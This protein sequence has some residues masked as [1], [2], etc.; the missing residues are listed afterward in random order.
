MFDDES[1]KK[2]SHVNCFPLLESFNNQLEHTF[3]L[4]TASSLGTVGVR[5]VQG[6]PLWSASPSK[7][8]PR[9]ATPCSATQPWAPTQRHL[10]TRH[11]LLL[12]SGKKV[13]G[14]GKQKNKK[15]TSAESKQLL[16]VKTQRPQNA[17][18]HMVPN[19]RY[20]DL[21]EAVHVCMR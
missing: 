13:G 3:R 17:L 15:S 20:T 11:T 8:L 6:P 7:M 1:S 19:G 21:C 14:G 2:Y 10:G 5:D 18:P 4:T 16:K 12:N 9:L